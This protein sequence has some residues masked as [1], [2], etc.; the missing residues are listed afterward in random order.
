MIKKLDRVEL[1]LFCAHICQT[2]HRGM[3][4]GKQDEL[5]PSVCDAMNQLT[6]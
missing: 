2:L 6:S 5:S 3:D 4:G 1:G